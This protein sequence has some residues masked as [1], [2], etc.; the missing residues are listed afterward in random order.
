MPHIE[1]YPHIR[2]LPFG[3]LDLHFA[4][5]LATDIEFYHLFRC[6]IAHGQVE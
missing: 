3:E 6:A 4:H 5:S 1:K 2:L